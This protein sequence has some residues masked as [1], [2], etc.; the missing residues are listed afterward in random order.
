MIIITKGKV[1]REDDLFRTGQGSM[2]LH[3]Q[4]IKP[5]V[6]YA[7]DRSIFLRSSFIPR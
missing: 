2:K 3:E 1:N 7:V 5:F 6:R 4:V